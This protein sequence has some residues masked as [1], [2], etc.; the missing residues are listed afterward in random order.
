M[1]GQSP[2]ASPEAQLPTASEHRRQR[3]RRLIAELTEATDDNGDSGLTPVKLALQL[4]AA[5]QVPDENNGSHDTQDK[6]VALAPAS[7]LGGPPP[8]P[9]PPMPACL[10]GAPPPPPMPG[11][12]TSASAAP[13]PAAPADPS[14]SALS[15]M[16]KRLR[17]RITKAP[18][19][20]GESKAKLD[21]KVRTCS[22]PIVGVGL[23]PLVGIATDTAVGGD[24]VPHPQDNARR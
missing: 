17:N 7:V 21:D 11:M 3:T 5:G 18:K 4:E 1:H 23:T 22:T 14:L 16:Q 13:A 19:A 12:L 6:A 20:S 24:P 15:R 10:G 9:P 2:A 8:P